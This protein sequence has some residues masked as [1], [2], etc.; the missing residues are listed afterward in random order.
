MADDWLRTGDNNHR[1]P[2]APSRFSRK[3]RRKENARRD[4]KNK[5]FHKIIVLD[6]LLG[7]VD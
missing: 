6:V 1:A 7:L 4:K 2:S 5:S 3:N